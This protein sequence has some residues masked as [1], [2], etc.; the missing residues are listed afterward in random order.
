MFKISTLALGYR[1]GVMHVSSSVCADMRLYTDSCSPKQ[2]TVRE[3]YLSGLST[4]YGVKVGSG[5]A[6]ELGF[7]L[8]IGKCDCYIH[9]AKVQRYRLCQ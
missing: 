1:E 3:T 6:H 8:F 7:V 4:S 2:Y 9:A 5:Y